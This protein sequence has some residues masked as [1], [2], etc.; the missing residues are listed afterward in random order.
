MLTNPLSANYLARD[1]ALLE[2]LQPLLNCLSREPSTLPEEGTQ[3]LSPGL[4][5]TTPVQRPGA[6]R[7]LRGRGDIPLTPAYTLPLANTSLFSGSVI[8]ISVWGGFF[9]FNSTCE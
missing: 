6:E 9:S 7:L 2:D 8:S 5:K 1:G 4:A 3:D